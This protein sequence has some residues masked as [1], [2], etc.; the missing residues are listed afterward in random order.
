MRIDIIIRANG[1]WAC[2]S[3]SVTNIIA[4]KNNTKLKFWESI[5]ELA[6]LCGM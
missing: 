3:S 2:Q 1:S 6:A 4:L 5:P